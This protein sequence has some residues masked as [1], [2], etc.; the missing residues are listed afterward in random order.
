ME[1][2][3]VWS[4]N[5]IK[6]LLP[7]NIFFV[8]LGQI[9]SNFDTTQ[10]IVYFKLMSG[11]A[12][13][14]H[15][16]NPLHKKIWKLQFLPQFKIMPPYPSEFQ[17]NV[18]NTLAILGLSQTIII[19]DRGTFTLQPST[20]LQRIPYIILRINTFLK[21][22]FL[23]LLS[24]GFFQS[25][26]EFFEKMAIVLWFLILILL[27]TSERIW[28][29]TYPFFEIITAWWNVQERVFNRLG[30]PDTFVKDVRQIAFSRVWF[31]GWDF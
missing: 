23:V 28:C 9:L 18:F 15:F 21:L 30:K 26:F 4:V 17:Q 13:L 22:T 25:E 10:L 16:P 11:E 12:V 1:W 19:R 6:W 14:S 27:T 2:I 29:R 24:C 7:N 20:F 8:T 3:S 31:Q 5:N